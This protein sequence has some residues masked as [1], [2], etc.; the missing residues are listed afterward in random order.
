MHLLRSKIGPKFWFFM[1]D[2]GRF[3]NMRKRLSALEYPI[4]LRQID[5]YLVFS[6]KDLQITLVEELPV[7]GRVTPE[8]LK[9]V[10]V[11]IGKC[12]LKGSERLQAFHEAGKKPPEPSKIRVATKEIKKTKPLTAPEVAKILGIS[13]NSVRR[14]P[15]HQLRY[16]RTKGKHRRYSIG[17]VQAYR[18]LNIAPADEESPDEPVTA[19]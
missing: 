18:E 17:A 3:L 12:W 8:F 4:T 5:T 19:P 1:G 2:F 6:V 11:M 9:R 10:A 7:G 15:K 14:I 16:R 13:V